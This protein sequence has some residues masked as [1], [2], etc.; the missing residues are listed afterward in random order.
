MTGFLESLYFKTV[1]CSKETIM[2]LHNVEHLKGSDKCQLKAA[3]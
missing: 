1:N 2:L 3:S